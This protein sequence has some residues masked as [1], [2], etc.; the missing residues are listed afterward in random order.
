[1]AVTSGPLGAAF[2]NGSKIVSRLPGKTGRGVK[3]QHVTVI[4]LDEAQDYPAPGWDNVVECLN[5]DEAEARWF[6]SGVSNGVR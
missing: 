3:G 5:A 2:A 4:L 6:V 1:M